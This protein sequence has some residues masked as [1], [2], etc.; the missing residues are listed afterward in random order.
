MT[1]LKDSFCQ[2]QPPEVSWVVFL[3]ISQNS[4]ENTCAPESHFILRP[5]TLLKKDSGTGVF[6]WILWKFW[7]RIFYRTP[8]DDCF[9]FSPFDH[10]N[11]QSFWRYDTFGTTWNFIYI[12][13]KTA[14]LGLFESFI[15][16]PWLYWILF[17]K[18][19]FHTEAYSEPCQ[20]SSMERFTVNYFCRTIHL[21][22]L[23][24][25]W[26]SKDLSWWRYLEDVLNTSSA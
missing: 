4:L 2:K 12:F 8:L 9:L 20:I 19:M 5:A 3:E 14:L 24:W 13:W 11:F 7:E 15:N 21:R 22:Y 10:F 6:L 26:C 25:F 16:L 23:T 17:F 1:S 18:L